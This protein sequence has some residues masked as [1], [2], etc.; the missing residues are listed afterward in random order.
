MSIA[1]G[2]L[3]SPLS[4]AILNCW[5]ISEALWISLRLEREKRG[6]KTR[7]RLFYRRRPTPRSRLRISHGISSL[8]AGE[9]YTTIANY[10][11]ISLRRS[12]PMTSAKD[13]TH[14]VSYDIHLGYI[15]KFKENHMHRHHDLLLL[16]PAVIAVTSGAGEDAT[17]T[18]PRASWVDRG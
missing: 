9:F 14:N 6:P 1:N 11:P 8:W 2:Y 15:V 5:E 4:I 3:S 10:N 13:L 18:L 16:K 17:V 7:P 12:S